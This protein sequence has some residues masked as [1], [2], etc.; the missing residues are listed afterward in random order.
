LNCCWPGVCYK[1]EEYV[2]LTCW[3]LQ[4]GNSEDVKLEVKPCLIPESLYNWLV[5]QL[6]GRMEEFTT[7][8]NITSFFIWAVESL[9]V[10][11]VSWSFWIGTCLSS[12]SSLWGEC[13][14][15]CECNAC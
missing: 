1:W 15:R 14:S 6:I 9:V 3:I 5:Q 10:T 13:L 8:M 2:N 7:P 11:S 12:F 4:N